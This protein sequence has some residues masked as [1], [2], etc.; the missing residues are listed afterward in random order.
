MADEKTINGK[1]V[2]DFRDAGSEK[3]FQKD[4]TY[5]FGEGAFG[6]YEHAGLVTHADDGSA[7]SEPLPAPAPQPGA[8]D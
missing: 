5:S 7:M 6:N 8:D 4:K 1:A 3:L 2:R